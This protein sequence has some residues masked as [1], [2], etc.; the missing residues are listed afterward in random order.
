MSL[1]ISLRSATIALLSLAMIALSPIS[2]SPAHAQTVT[3]TA[4]PFGGIATL[5]APQVPAPGIYEYTFQFSRPGTGIAIIDYV[6]TYNVFDTG[7]N[8]LFGNDLSL[9]STS[10]FPAPVTSGS[11]LFELPKPYSTPVAGGIENGLFYTTGAFLDFDFGTDDPVDFSITLAR[12]LPTVGGVPE[13]ATW[14]MMM[15]GFGVIG[16]AMRRRNALISVRV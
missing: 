10:L 14:A 9:V 7:G 8:F 15:L 11:F 16:A 2:S 1:G 3:G 13:P 6:Q 5:G 12:Y 4:N